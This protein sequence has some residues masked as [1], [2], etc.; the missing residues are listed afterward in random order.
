MMM[1]NDGYFLHFNNNA[2]IEEYRKLLK[3]SEGAFFGQGS[4][5][6][7]FDMTMYDT[8]SDWWVTVTLFFEYTIEN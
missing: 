8:E 4:K 2:T 5:G 1:T 3:E 7:V 6:I